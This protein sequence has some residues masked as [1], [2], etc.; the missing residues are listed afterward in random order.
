MLYSSSTVFGL[1]FRFDPSKLI[2]GDPRLLL[3]PRGSSWSASGGA[4]VSVLVSWG[5]RREQFGI[6]LLLKQLE[7]TPFDSLTAAAA[8]AVRSVAMNN[9]ANKNAVRE[10]WGIPLLAKMLGPEVRFQPPLPQ[11]RPSPLSLLL[12]V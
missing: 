4:T 3:E 8:D 1:D 9:D 2:A 7:G 10:N 11:I 6:P 5:T 12:V